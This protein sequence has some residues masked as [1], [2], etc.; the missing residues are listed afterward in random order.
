MKPA[1][2]AGSYRARRLGTNL[3][4]DIAVCLSP[5][6][7]VR[8]RY[9]R[10]SDGAGERGGWLMSCLLAP[11]KAQLFGSNTV[12]SSVGCGGA[13]LPS[14]RHPIETVAA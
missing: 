5:R 6:S 13:T 11:Q 4:D 14:I 7:D 1:V 2:A 10:G 3:V 12:N 9:E 8:Y